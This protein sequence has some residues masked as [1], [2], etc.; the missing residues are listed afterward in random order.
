MVLSIADKLLLAAVQE[1]GQG[2]RADVRGLREIDGRP[3]EGRGR[4]REGGE[5]SARG[6]RGAVG[7]RGGGGAADTSGASSV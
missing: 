4:P 5:R 6:G 7:P 2:Q 3:D 1:S